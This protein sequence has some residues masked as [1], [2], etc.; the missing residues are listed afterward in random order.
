[1]NNFKIGDIVICI[2]ADKA[3]GV[4]LGNWYKVH[5]V[6]TTILEIFNDFG[7]INSLS[8]TRFK[9]KAN[10]FKIGDNVICINFKDKDVIQ[11]KVQKNQVYQVL[12]VD[13]QPEDVFLTSTYIEGKNMLGWFFSRT[14]EKVPTNID[15][16]EEQFQ[17]FIK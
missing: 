16:I 1:M 15:L 12:E 5:R 8:Y 11:K 9:L 10:N 4:T 13:D 14:F 2:D 6:G 7:M 17:P 3:R